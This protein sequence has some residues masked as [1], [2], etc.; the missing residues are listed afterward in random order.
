MS[1]VAL[2]C[3]V[4]AQKHQASPCPDGPWPWLWP[5]LGPFGP[6][7]NFNL[8]AR[9]GPGPGPFG[10]RANFLAYLGQGPFGSIWTLGPGPDFFKKFA[11]I[12][13]FGGPDMS[14]F[15]GAIF[16]EGFP[17]NGEHEFRTGPKGQ[18]RA[19]GPRPADQG[20]RSPM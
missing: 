18:G 3:Q 9:L 7:A 16:A 13:F 4:L 17:S 6:W 5:D 12:D 20:P 15:P 1:G 19:Q 14:F 11:K 10:P 8:F 2:N